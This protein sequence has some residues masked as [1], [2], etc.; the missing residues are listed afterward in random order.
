LRA[1]LKR[2]L[3]LLLF[4]PTSLLKPAKMPNSAKMHSHQLNNTIFQCSRNLL[5]RLG[6][7]TVGKFGSSEAFLGVFLFENE[8]PLDE[9]GKVLLKGVVAEGYLLLDLAERVGFAVFKRS[10][11]VIFKIV[12]FSL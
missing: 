4:A 12:H 10:Q 7:D 5:S 2:T 3:R 6:R 11:Y 1:D 8:T 9:L